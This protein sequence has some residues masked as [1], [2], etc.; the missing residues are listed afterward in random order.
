MGRSSSTRGVAFP[1][2]L[3]V[4]VLVA[5]FVIALSTLQHSLKSQVYHSC[6]HQWSF[7]LAYS[8]MSK[9]LARI[10]TSS[11][12]NRPFATSPYREF[13]VPLQGGTYDLFVENTPG[14]EYQA[15]IYVKTTLTGVSRLYFWRITYNDDLL[16]ISNRIIV[17]FFKAAEPTVFPTAAGPSNFSKL[18]DDLLAERARNQKKSDEMT[19]RLAPLSDPKAVLAE[20]QGRTPETFTQ[21]WPADPTEVAMT[22][23]PAA[24]FPVVAPPGADE[25]PTAGG[26]G[27]AVSIAGGGSSSP[28]AP[29]FPNIPITSGGSS[30]NITSLTDTLR[31]ATQAAEQA[32]ANYDQ[33]KY[34]ADAGHGDWEGARPN[35]IAANAARLEAIQNMGE[36]AS[37]AKDALQQSTSAEEAKALQEWVSSSMVAAYQNIANGVARA[38]EDFAQGAA[39]VSYA[40]T[41]GEA[42][43]LL[44][45][46]IGS[47]ADLQRIRSEMNSV[48]SEIDGFA[49]TSEV[50]A[51][52]AAAN[53]TL[54][55]TEEMCKAAIEAAKAR[56]AELKAQEEA[57]A[58]HAA[59][60]DQ[61]PSGG[62]ATP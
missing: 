12:T 23:R 41:S 11:W 2:I 33:G 38:Y 19:A 46:W 50:A 10:H 29:D 53:Q 20:L 8:A 37:L 5:G 45:T 25:V 55:R 32:K 40:T 62:T 34:I 22:G 28:R 58:R 51:A 59:N 36:A 42:Q 6:N 54:A 49:K 14:R 43:A 17:E 27:P 31:A 52:Q 61:T 4:I 9:M 26:P 60:T 24:P 1:V 57:A 44:D 47:L 39:I 56:V 7:L 3:V 30:A 48:M 15:D 13:G 21:S 35:L 16:D 18:V